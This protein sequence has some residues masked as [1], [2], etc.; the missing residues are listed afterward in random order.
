MTRYLA[1]LRGINVGGKNVIKMADLKTRFQEEGF[2]DVATYIQS[3]NVLFDAQPASLRDLTMHIEASLT[4]AFDY[5]A[6]VVLRHH[7]QMRSIVNGA[8]SGFGEDPARYRSD[9]IFLKAPLKAATAIERVVTRDGVDHAQ[10]GNG[11][12]YFARLAS[13]AGQSY[14]SKIVSLPVYQQMTIRNWST[15]TRLLA[16]MDESVR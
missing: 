13:R 7:K 14:L 5:P 16:L 15:T 12:L 1:L 4:R 8:P 6:S 11:V 3:G 10:A 9:V 2:G